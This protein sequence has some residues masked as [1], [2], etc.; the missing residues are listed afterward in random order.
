[1]IKGEVVATPIDIVLKNKR[2]FDQRL[3]QLA[4]TLGN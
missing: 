4:E 1:M 2:T 3:I